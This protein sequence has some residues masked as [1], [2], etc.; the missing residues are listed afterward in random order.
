MVSFCLIQPFFELYF[1]PFA[2]SYT[3]CDALLS[4]MTKVRFQRFQAKMGHNQGKTGLEAARRLPRGL[5][6]LLISH[7]L[8]PFCLLWRVKV[9]TK[10]GAGVQDSIICGTSIVPFRGQSGTLPPLIASQGHC[11]INA[12]E[13]LL[14]L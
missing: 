7:K 11:M 9:R 4:T 2:C 12:E 13:R 3:C 14:Y 5:F 8:V 10:K 1:A 6:F